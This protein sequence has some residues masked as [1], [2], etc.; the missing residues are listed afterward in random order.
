[1]ILRQVYAELV[2]FVPR[3]FRLLLD[4]SLG[5]FVQNTVFDR[6][7]NSGLITVSSCDADDLDELVVFYNGESL[8]LR[9][10]VNFFLTNI[11]SYD[12]PAKLLSLFNF[13]RNDHSYNH[14]LL[15]DICTS[16]SSLSTLE[17][18]LEDKKQPIF[19]RYF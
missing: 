2:S 11:H 5:L 3:Q 4:P 14:D 18:A 12:S 7:A 16:H 10:G 6:E 19:A 1:M 13:T 15:R 9:L 17:K 8:N